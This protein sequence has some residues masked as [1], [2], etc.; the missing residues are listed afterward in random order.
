MLFR[1]TDPEMLDEGRNNYMSSLHI[2]ETGFALAYCDITTGVLKTSPFTNMD[3]VID[4]LMKLEPSELIL[5]DKIKLTP[6]AIKAIE[7]IGITLTPFYEHAFT[8]VTGK[9]IVERILNVFSVESL[10]FGDHDLTLCATGALLAYV[11]ETA[12]VPLNHFSK[13]EIYHQNTF[14]MLDKFTRR[15]LELVETMRS[16]EKKGSLLWVLDKT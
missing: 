4:E 14:M 6:A 12:K 15:N 13:I 16:K 7:D 8:A 11:E 3:K 2:D 10:G 5:S 9:K 1:S